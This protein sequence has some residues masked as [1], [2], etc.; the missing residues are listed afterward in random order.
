MSEVTKALLLQDIVRQKMIDI[1][2]GSLHLICEDL[3]E[4]GRPPLPSRTIVFR[5]K[6]NLEAINGA[7]QR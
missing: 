2:I 6:S 3:R 7:S 4:A 1:L 5:P